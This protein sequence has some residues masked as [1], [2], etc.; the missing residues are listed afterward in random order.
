MHAA[1]MGV[2][3]CAIPCSFFVTNNEDN[4]SHVTNSAADEARRM[5][6]A[7]VHHEYKSTAWLRRL[8]AHASKYKL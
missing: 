3:A 8:G 5:H 6:C 1:G 4:A 2:A 7:G